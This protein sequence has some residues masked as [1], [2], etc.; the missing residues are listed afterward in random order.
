MGLLISLKT[1]TTQAMDTVPMPTTASVIHTMA[2]N[3]MTIPMVASCLWIRPRTSTTQVMD[4]VPMPTTASV[5]H[6]TAA[7]ATTIH[8]VALCLWTKPSL[9]KRPRESTSTVHTTDTASTT[10]SFATEA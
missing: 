5:I 10:Q 6:I 2:A 7:N 9:Q 8:A 4:T 3:A 1:S